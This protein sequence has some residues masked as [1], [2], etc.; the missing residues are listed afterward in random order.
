MTSREAALHRAACRRGTGRV[1]GSTPRAPPWGAVVRRVAQPQ[2]EAGDPGPDPP[3]SSR[4]E[5]P[6]AHRREPSDEARDNDWQSATPPRAGG[7]PALRASQSHCDVLPG[8]A[9]LPQRG[10]PSVR[11]AGSRQ[12]ARRFFETRGRRH[13]RQSCARYREIGPRFSAARG[14]NEVVHRAYCLYEPALT[15]PARRPRRTY[16]ARKV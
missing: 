6:R 3:A 2:S 4:V 10:E 7:G 5:E 1:R 14:A 8:P 13:P 11:R 9:T 16:S 12:Q 15:A